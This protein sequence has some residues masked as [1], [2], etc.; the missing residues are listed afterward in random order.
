MV[1]EEIAY[2]VVCCFV[3]FRIQSNDKL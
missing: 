2:K 3:Q 1:P